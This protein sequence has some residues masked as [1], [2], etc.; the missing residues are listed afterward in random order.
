MN[1]VEV[2]STLA[3]VE[4]TPMPSLPESSTSQTAQISI[5][6]PSSCTN[7]ADFIHVTTEN[8][9]KDD[10]FFKHSV[11]SITTINSDTNTQ[12]AIIAKEII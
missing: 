9:S 8:Q 3:S 5:Y 4:T 1:K 11:K 10:V 2:S 7:L 6:F 12:G